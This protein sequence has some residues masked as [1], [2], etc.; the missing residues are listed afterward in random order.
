LSFRFSIIADAH[1][2]AGESIQLE[3]LRLALRGCK[4]KGDEFVIL[5]GDCTA[6]GAPPS[7]RQLRKALDESGMRWFAV[8][9][10]NESQYAAFAEYLGRPLQRVK[11]NGFEII[12]ADTAEGDLSDESWE[13][14]KGLPRAS[15][16]EAD[17]FRLL[18][19]HHYFEC[20]PTD[21]RRVL[22]DICREKGIRRV[23]SAHRH[24]NETHHHGGVRE[25]ILTCLD[26]DKARDT[27]P[28]Y[29]RISVAAGELQI[30]FC[31]VTL[32]RER[33]SGWRP[34]FGFSQVKSDEPLAPWLRLCRRFGFQYL[35]VRMGAVQHLPSPGEVESAH[36]MGIGL[37]AHLPTPKLS[38]SG[39]LANEGELGACFDWARDNADLI[40]LHP[41]KLPE[42][43]FYGRSE[44]RD[45][46]AGRL[47]QLMRRAAGIPIAVENNS[48]K[49]EICRFG[50]MPRHLLDFSEWLGL[51][52]VRHGFC[53]DVGHAKASRHTAQVYEWFQALGRRMLALHL[54]TG[55]PSS[56]AT[57][58]PIT[59][60]FTRTTNWYG[61]LAWVVS[62][63]RDAP[64]IIETKSLDAAEISASL[65]GRLHLN[66]SR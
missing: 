21:S 35:Q 23:I 44:L 14:L 8:R 33:F 24:I 15:R 62:V 39:E 29:H 25:D 31:E 50:S 17:S 11:R 52:D 65:L 1:I 40:I 57:H 59:K 60:P 42:R 34:A 32:P 19:L 13:L 63:C 37:I 56:R 27:L 20:L 48:S 26:A 2:P 22:I 46:A 12:A 58:E 5:L 7:Y 51:I 43:E 47:A 45:E 38:E 18:L 66:L 64:L 61:I 55:E 54:H 3:H 30:R 6:D 49:G 4:A 28:G 9:G 36:G 41:P 10:N 16:A 53:F